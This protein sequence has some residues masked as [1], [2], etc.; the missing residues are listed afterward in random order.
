MAKGIYNRIGIE[1]GSYNRGASNPKWKGGR[2]INSGYV[3]VRN[4]ALQ[5][6]DARGHPRYVLEHRLVA[7]QKLGRPLR[8]D[9]EVHHINGIRDDNRPENIE[10]MSKARHASIH[11]KVRRRDGRWVKQQ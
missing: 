7:E 10:V 6:A 11:P 3:R 5:L 2:C 1:R 4:P 8:R 9:E